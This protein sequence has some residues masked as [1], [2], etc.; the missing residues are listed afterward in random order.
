MTAR[1]LGESNALL[2]PAAHLSGVVVFPPLE[3]HRLDGLCRRLV[4]GFLV[5]A[6]DLEAVCHVVHH[7]A[8]REQGVVLEDHGD[9]V[10]PELQ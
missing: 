5:H 9:L 7:T 6:A 2:H 1:A 8:V 10:A 3:T 4:P